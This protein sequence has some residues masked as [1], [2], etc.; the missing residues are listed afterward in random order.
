MRINFILL[1]IKRGKYI[2]N[3]KFYH[4]LKSGSSK[5]PKKTYHQQFLI[6]FNI[7]FP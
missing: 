1:Y 7:K 2:V 4:C 6:Y 3:I 5:D